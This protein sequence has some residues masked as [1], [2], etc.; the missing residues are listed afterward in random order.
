MQGKRVVILVNADFESRKHELSR[1]GPRAYEADAAVLDTARSVATAAASLGAEVS[2]LRV[3]TSLRNLVSELRRREADVVFN[4]V[5]SIDNDY[6]REWQVPALLERHGIPYTGN[7]ARP[8]RLCRTKDHA[9]RLLAAAGVRV[10]EGFVLRQPSDLAR[11]AATLHFPLFIKP[12]RV[13]GS[14]GID[15]DSICADLPALEHKLR[16]LLANLPG[17]FLVEEFLPGKELNVAIFPSPRGG[18][19]V[20]TEIDFSP[21][22]AEYPRIVT[23]DSKWNA[24]SPEYASTSVPAQ[25]S[26]AL[27]QEV[28]ELARRAFLALG[29]TGYGRV[30]MRLSAAGQPAVIDVNPNNDIDTGAG[31]AKA[32]RSVGVDYP[33]LIGSVLSAAL[34]RD[35]A[36]GESA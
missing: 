21:V 16:Q 12:A 24:D 4:L 15:R 13:D 2:E 3:T 28:C 25:L 1:E 9:R 14:I 27:Q 18:W 6:G 5:E 22:P 7:G 33:T 29:G 17:P 35:Q 26:P 11:R 36:R 32:A 23:Y 20:P 30:D 19:V 8:L 31:L 10:A 34:E